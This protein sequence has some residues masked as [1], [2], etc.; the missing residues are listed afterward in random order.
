M[1]AGERGAGLGRAGLAEEESHDP[2]LARPER[3]AT[4]GGEVEFPWIPADF[5][6]GGGKALAAEPLLE[7]P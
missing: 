2:A 3:Q 7:G 6:E 5:R 4:A 1:P